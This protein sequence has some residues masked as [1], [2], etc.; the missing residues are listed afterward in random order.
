MSGVRFTLP[1]VG[2]LT[3]LL[4][5]LDILYVNTVWPRVRSFDQNTLNYWR[6]GQH[7]RWDLDYDRRTVVVPLAPPTDWWTR[8]RLM[9]D[10]PEI[11]EEFSVRRQALAAYNQALPN[12]LC[13]AYPGF[14][15]KGSLAEYCAREGTHLARVKDQVAIA[16]LMRGY[17]STMADMHVTYGTGL[18]DFNEQRF[19]RLLPS[20]NDA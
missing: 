10:F 20:S 16:L 18:V 9:G 12:P 19:L 3:T 4:R 8:G 11:D 6:W 1:G 7:P 2:E 15:S 14:P 5:V 13:G 17:L